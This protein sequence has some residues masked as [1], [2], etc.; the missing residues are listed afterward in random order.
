MAAG[1]DAMGKGIFSGDV[2]NRPQ[3]RI[4]LIA[5]AT[6]QNHRAIRQRFLPRRFV[7]K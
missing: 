3:Q 5:G 4:S 7:T 6:P 1:R 2:V